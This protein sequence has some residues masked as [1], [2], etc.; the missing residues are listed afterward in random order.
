VATPAGVRA[1]G[2]V[3]AFTL[4]FIARGD[5]SPLRSVGPVS[6]HRNALNFFNVARSLRYTTQGGQRAHIS[7]SSWA[8]S[9]LRVSRPFFW[10]SERVTVIVLLLRSS[11][12]RVGP[13][14]SEYAA[15]LPHTNVDPT[16]HSSGF[17]SRPYL[18]SRERWRS[19]WFSPANCAYCEG[20]RLGLA[21][22]TSD[23]PGVP[24]RTR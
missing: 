17:A 12:C 23:L 19:L 9:I 2:R 6:L 11:M 18:E 10:N 5:H 7:V 15:P 8:V 13:V 14:G 1:L 24:S 4:P 3:P 22:R 20:N 16:S 21:T